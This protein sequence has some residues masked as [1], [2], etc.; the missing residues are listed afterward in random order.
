VLVVVEADAGEGPEDEGH[1]SQ[2]DSLGHGA[3]QSA[4]VIMDDENT[5]KLKE[6]VK[7]TGD[8]DGGIVYLL[9]HPVGAFC[10]LVLDAFEVEEL[11]L[12]YVE[13]LRLINKTI[14][15]FLVRTKVLESPKY[16]VPNREEPTVILVQTVSV[17]SM[18]DLM[19]SRSVED[20]AKRTNVT[21]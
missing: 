17:G 9:V 11:V 16:S 20:P 18:V 19:K 4:Q 5:N 1:H 21:Y 3:I 14:D 6:K 2:G 7:M 10:N 12:H 8:V 15:S 13:K